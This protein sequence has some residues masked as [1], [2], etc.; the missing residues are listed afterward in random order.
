MKIKPI[1]VCVLLLSVLFSTWLYGAV[2]LN[3]KA[4]QTYT[5]KKG[6]TLWDIPGMY[7]S[8]PWLWPELWDVNP[9]IDN[10]RV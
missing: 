3:E 1:S 8:Q 10:H 2:E 7:L 9:Q 5:V 4:P 6:D